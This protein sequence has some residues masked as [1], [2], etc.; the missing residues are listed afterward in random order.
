MIEILLALAPVFLLIA[1]GNLIRR[2]G[3]LPADFWAGAEKLVYWGLFPCLL[4]RKAALAPLDALEPGPLVIT[5]VGGIAVAGI[6]VLALK[7]WLRLSDPSLGSVF[8]AAIRMNVYIGFAAASALGGPHGQALAALCAAIMV[9]AVNAFSIVVLLGLHGG[10]KGKEAR[11]RGPKLWLDVL[12]GV[13]THQLILAIV[14]GL[15]VNI[16]G[17]G[18]PPVVDGLTEILSSGALPLALLTVGA[19]LQLR[20]LRSIGRAMVT[21]IIA[22]LVVQPLAAYGIAASLGLSGDAL[23]VALIF[24]ALPCSPSGYHMAR[25]MGGDGPLIAGLITAQTFLAAILLPVVILLVR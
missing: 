6:V 9:P 7:P 11:P 25:Q 16:A 13:V 5:L 3:L 2:N 18:I 17:I 20:A 8:Q 10:A 19:G 21:G 23:L 24:A 22:K 1:G 15:G 4:F 12:R 14:L